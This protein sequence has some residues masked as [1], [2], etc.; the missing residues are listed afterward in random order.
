M[1]GVEF[2]DNLSMI[3][4]LHLFK[5]FGVI[6]DPLNIQSKKRGMLLAK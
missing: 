5:E 4:I 6:V 3:N 1:D 2:H